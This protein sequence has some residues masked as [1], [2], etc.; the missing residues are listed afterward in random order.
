[1]ISLIVSYT[2]FRVLL[3]FRLLSISITCLNTP[4]FY[5]IWHYFG[6][7]FRIFPRRIANIQQKCAAAKILLRTRNT[8]HATKACDVVFP[9]C[10]LLRNSFFAA[11][12]MC[13]TF[14]KSNSFSA[15]NKILPF[16]REDFKNYRRFCHSLR[17]CK[18]RKMCTLLFSSF[19]K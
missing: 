6:K 4:S 13:I 17:L 14:L 10:Q 19:T 1:M 15:K 9:Q 8:Q 11:A 12:G 7:I 18:I 3:F 16:Y 5:I 2:P